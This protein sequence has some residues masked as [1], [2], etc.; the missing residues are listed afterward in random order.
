MKETSSTQRKLRVAVDIDADILS[1]IDN[2]KVQM[3]FGSRGFVINQLLRELL[4]IDDGNV[5]DK[6]AHT[7]KDGS[8]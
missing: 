4:I 8:A 5:P 6:L 7:E 2:I 3:G 1:A